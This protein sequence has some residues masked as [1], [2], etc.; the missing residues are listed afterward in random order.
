MVEGMVERM[1]RVL[2]GSQATKA[3]VL[4]GSQATKARNIFFI[5]K[6]EKEKEGKEVGE[7]KGQVLAYLLL[8]SMRENCGQVY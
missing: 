6:K 8:R 5:R 3:R 1:E 2:V 4:E 7:K